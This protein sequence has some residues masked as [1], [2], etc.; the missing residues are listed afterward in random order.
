MLVSEERM[1][2]SDGLLLA[3]PAQGLGYQLMGAFRRL[4][5]R[6]VALVAGELEREALKQIP[7]QEILFDWKQADPKAALPA[8]PGSFSALFVTP[9][10]A[11][12]LGLPLDAPAWWSQLK[13]LELVRD[14]NPQ[15]HLL[16]TLAAAESPERVDEILSRFS[17]ATVFIAPP[18][19]GFRDGGLMDEALA[20]LARDPAALL[21]EIPPMPATAALAYAGDV[22]A[23]LMS[24]VGQERLFGKA[25]FVEPS[26]TSLESWRA[27]FVRHFQVEAGALARLSARFSDRRPFVSLGSLRQ[28]AAVRALSGRPTDLARNFFPTASTPLERAMRN[29]AEYH[30]RD[31]ALG[32]VFPPGRSL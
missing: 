24:A 2:E 5:K 22:A 4:G 23:L 15:A 21:R 32:L 28:A 9:H 3:S 27:S 30:R 29:L 8:K 19:Y 12:G 18:L 11:L 1:T 20:L 7:T 17:R 26:V 13:L 10:P 6:T 31:P 25:L 16:V 14:A